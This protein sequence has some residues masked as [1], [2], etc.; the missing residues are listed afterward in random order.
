MYYHCSEDKGD[1]QI[2]SYCEADL[3]LCF[4][5]GKNK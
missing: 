1:D 2:C 3:R 5:I 4:R